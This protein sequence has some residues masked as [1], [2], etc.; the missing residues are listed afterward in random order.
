M[1]EK[2]EPRRSK[3]GREQHSFYLQPERKR[4]I[5]QLALDKGITMTELLEGYVEAGL[6]KDGVITT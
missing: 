6:R 4:Q 1:R 3:D 5:K 2:K